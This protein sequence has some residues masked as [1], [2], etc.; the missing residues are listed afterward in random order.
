[1]PVFPIA[2]PIS[3]LQAVFLGQLVEERLLYAQSISWRGG[4]WRQLTTSK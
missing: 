2:R 1:M 3:L 4:K